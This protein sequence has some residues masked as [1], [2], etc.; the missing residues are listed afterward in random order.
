MGRQE[1]HQKGF[2]LSMHIERVY[3]YMN[4]FEARS[5]VTASE[6]MNVME[7]SRST[8][9]RDIAFLRDRFDVPI[10]F[11]RDLAAYRLEK[12]S[13]KNRIPGIWFNSREIQIL[14]LLEQQ[15]LEMPT[16]QSNKEIVE[17]RAKLARVCQTN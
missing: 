10:I 4:F 7:I 13:G 2:D 8:F 15:L 17:L 6:F 9:K 3:L 12:S 14:K 11:D 16:T 5:F 1:T